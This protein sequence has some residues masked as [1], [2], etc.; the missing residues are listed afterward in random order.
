MA[1]LQNYK[2]NVEGSG[3]RLIVIEWCTEKLTSQ[4]KGYELLDEEIDISLD[5]FR[6]KYADGHG[7][8]E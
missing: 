1:G 7:N 3:M 6:Q 2:T 5:E 8:P 4:I